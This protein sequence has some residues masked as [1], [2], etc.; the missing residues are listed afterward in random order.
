[1]SSDWNM[2]VFSENVSAITLNK[3][4]EILVHVGEKSYVLQRCVCRGE[5]ESNIDKI[6]DGYLSGKRVVELERQ[7]C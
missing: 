1:M 3:A 5:A 4:N 2:M 7:S 6:M